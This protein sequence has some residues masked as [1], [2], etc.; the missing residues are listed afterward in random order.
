[1]KFLRKTRD[2]YRSIRAQRA[3][4]MQSFSRHKQQNRTTSAGR[5]HDSMSHLLQAH[6]AVQ[7]RHEVSHFV[8]N[9]MQYRGSCHG[10]ANGRAAAKERRP[11]GDSI[12][13]VV[14]LRRTRVVYTSRALVFLNLARSE[15]SRDEVG[16]RRYN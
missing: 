4:M 16:I 10:P 15:D 11:D 9:L 14:Y 1:M 2:D 13:E 12:S 7:E 8:R 3:R 6:A 5:K